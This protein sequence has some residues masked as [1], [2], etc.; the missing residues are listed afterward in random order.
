MSKLSKFLIESNRPKVLNELFIELGNLKDVKMGN[1]R[2]KQ[3]LRLA[4]TAELDAS[5][6]YETMSEMTLDS[7]LKEVLLDV[8]KEEKV[9][10]G[11]F[12]YLLKMIDEEEDSSEEQGENEVEDL[13]G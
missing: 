12:R 10:A 13:I 11:E 4:I 9:H 5:N 3:I 1:D 8:A 2:D 7:D 6:L